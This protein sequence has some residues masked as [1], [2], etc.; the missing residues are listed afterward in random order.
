M[1]PIWIKIC[2]ITRAEDAHA[3]AALGVNAIGLV[4]YAR[5]PRAVTAHRAEAVLAD[6]SKS[7][8]VFALF[9]NPGREEVEAVLRVRRIDHLQ[10]HGEESAAFCESFGLPYMKAFRVQS[11]TA[12]LSDLESYGSAERIL[13][14]SYEKNMPGGTG[15]TFDWLQ[16]KTIRSQAMQPVV[17]AGGLRPDNVCNAI[18]TVRPFG[19]DVSSGVEASPGVKDLEKLRSFVEGVRSVEK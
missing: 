17:L 18:A 5:S 12:V 8:E 10:F 16:A 1:S 19:I 13:L 11:A 4:F 9:V 7:L 3:A 2:G 15:K 14:D 6:V